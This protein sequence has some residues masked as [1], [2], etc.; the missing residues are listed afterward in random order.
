MA[1]IIRFD[2]FRRAR[3]SETSGGDKR[4]GDNESG[5]RGIATEVNYRRI[6]AAERYATSAFRQELAKLRRPY[7]VQLPAD[8]DKRVLEGDGR[9]VEKAARHVES[10]PKE[11]RG[12]ILFQMVRAAH[13]GWVRDNPQ[14]FLD[15]RYGE[16]RYLFLPIELC[17]LDA[18]LSFQD[19]IM[20]PIHRLG[21]DYSWMSGDSSAAYLAR[22]RQYI[23]D[24]GLCN[25]GLAHYVQNLGSDYQALPAEISSL[26]DTRIICFPPFYSVGTV[27]FL[28]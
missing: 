17:G 4:N 15:V 25:D 13:D 8:F 11:K 22:R 26:T 21:L 28:C 6:T 18:Y 5:R 12:E 23:R 3:Q 1:K 2:D 27:I 19:L 7:K 20:E 16:Q 10:L 24:R 9:F 14:H